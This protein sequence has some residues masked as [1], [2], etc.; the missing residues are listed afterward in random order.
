[1]KEQPFENGFINLREYEIIPESI[2]QN[3]T[4][5]Q[6]ILRMTGIDFPYLETVPWEYI[7]EYPLMREW[8]TH[9]ITRF[10]KP[11]ILIRKKNEEGETQ[12]EQC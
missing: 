8:F 10:H 2:P 6:C 1:M 4:P 5:R 11:R 7:R 3:E 9:V 12:A